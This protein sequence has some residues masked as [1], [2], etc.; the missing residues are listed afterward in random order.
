MDRYQASTAENFWEEYTVDNKRMTF[1]AISTRLR[2]ERKEDDER[3][4]DLAKTEYYGQKWVEAFS[5]MKGGKK[6]MMMKST[7]IARRYRELKGKDVLL[8]TTTTTP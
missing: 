5:Y 6:M 4:A 2:S 7:D 3:V 1:T 8:L